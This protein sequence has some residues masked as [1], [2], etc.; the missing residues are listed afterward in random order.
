MLMRSFPAGV[1]LVLLVWSAGP[2]QA[3]MLWD[4]FNAAA[5]SGFDGHSFFTSERVAV[6]GS[7]WA[8]D[9]FVVT[10]QPW[11]VG[12]VRWAAGRNPN[13]EYTVEVIILRDDFTPLVDGLGDFDAT[14]AIDEYQVTGTYGTFFGYQVYNGSAVI[15]ATTLDP[16]HYYVGV[17]LVSNNGLGYGRN[18]M[19]T[20]GSGTLQ[21]ETMGYVYSPFFGVSDWLPVDDFPMETPTDYAFQLLGTQVPEPAGLLLLFG[22][23]LVGLRRRH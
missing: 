6:L 16:G 20:T 1:L 18:V 4:N 22:G 10:D 19:M 14:Y 23:A 11:S 7:S 21:G 3:D 5:E 15:P 12:E 2:A 13:Y 8:I 17:R 9:D